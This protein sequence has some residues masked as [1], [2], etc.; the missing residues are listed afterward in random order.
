VAR[1][2][3]DET[4][5]SPVYQI[6][7]IQILYTFPEFSLV[8]SVPKIQLLNAAVSSYRLINQVISALELH[9]AEWRI[10][11]GCP[12]GI[13]FTFLPQCWDCYQCSVAN[14][15]TRK[16]VNRYYQCKIFR[17]TQHVINMAYVPPIWNQ[18]SPCWLQTFLQAFGSKLT[19]PYCC[20]QWDLQYRQ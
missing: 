10:L 11:M 18:K 7:R 19:V 12:C 6:F 14:T 17:W 1:E 15:N 9:A 3:H 13:G 8:Q 5:F 2:V 20:T 4:N 16:M